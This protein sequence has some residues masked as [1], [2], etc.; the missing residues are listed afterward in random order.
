MTIHKP[1]EAA[2]IRV[3]KRNLPPTYPHEFDAL[4]E[5]FELDSLTVF[6]LITY[7]GARGNYECQPCCVANDGSAMFL[8]LEVKSDIFRAIKRQLRQRGIKHLVNIN[9]QG[10]ARRRRPTTLPPSIFPTTIK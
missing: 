7:N 5:L 8:I 10:K 1:S 3:W 9:E 4:L 6:G 2:T